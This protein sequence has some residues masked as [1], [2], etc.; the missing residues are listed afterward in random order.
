[1]IKIKWY[2]EGFDGRCGNKFKIMFIELG[3]TEVQI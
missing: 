1:M 2:V 3:E